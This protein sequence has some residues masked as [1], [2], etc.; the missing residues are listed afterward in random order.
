M[1]VGQSL[2]LKSQGSQQGLWKS[3]LEAGG[4]PGRPRLAV[5]SAGSGGNYTCA[6]PAPAPAPEGQ[7]SVS[8]KHLL[9]G[10]QPTANNVYRVNERMN[11]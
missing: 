5:T 10:A 7:V 8:F 11:E 2:S 4:R 9:D 6:L 3:E 1:D